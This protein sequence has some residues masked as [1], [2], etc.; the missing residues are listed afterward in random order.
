EVRFRPGFIFTQHPVIEVE[1]P[2][3]TVERVGKVHVV[4]NV[5]S[6]VVIVDRVTHEPIETRIAIT[7]VFAPP[8][9]AVGYVGEAVGYANAD[10][11]AIHFV[12]LVVFIGPPYAGA[13]ALAGGGNPV[14][15]VAIFLEIE[16]SVPRSPFGLNGMAGIV[17]GK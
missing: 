2:F 17:Y 11:H 15:S 12:R 1:Y 5:G 4:A 14:L 6:N 7:Q 13:Q 8:E 9:P 16:A 10:E 3:F